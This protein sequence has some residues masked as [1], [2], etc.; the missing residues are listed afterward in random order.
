MEKYIDFSEVFT[1]NYCEY[2]KYVIGNRAIPDLEDGCKPIHKRILWSMY[3][4][5]NTWDNKRIKANTA[6]GLVLGYS[7]HGDTSVYEAMVRFANDSVNLNLIDGKGAFGSITGRDVQPGAD[8]YVEVRLSE[9]AKEYLKD[10]KLNI[11]G[12]KDNYTLVRANDNEII[13][14]SK[15]AKNRV[16]IESDG[17]ITYYNKNNNNWD[18]IG[19]TST[20]VDGYRLSS[21]KTDKKTARRIALWVSQHIPTAKEMYKDWHTWAAL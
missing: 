7:P 4:N 17:N 14:M 15:D 9:I 12:M 5:N 16:S 21:I 8:R 19:N 3:V 13:W 6:K 2:S 20:E 18:N 11:A 10:I 1:K